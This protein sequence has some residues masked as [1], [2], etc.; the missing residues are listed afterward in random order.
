MEQASVGRRSEPHG[1][2]GAAM[3]RRFIRKGSV[4]S[5]DQT[6]DRK[7]QE[8]RRKIIFDNLIK[9]CGYFFTVVDNIVRILLIKSKVGFD[10][11]NRNG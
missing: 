2:D 10:N 9:M 11:V 3:Q 1:L 4:W 7:T 8:N 6:G 5:L